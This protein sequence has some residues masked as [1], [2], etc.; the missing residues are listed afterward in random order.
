MA[1]AAKEAV[2]QR[3]KTPFDINMRIIVC[4]FGFHKEQLADLT[5]LDQGLCRDKAGRI[6]ADLPNHHLGFC[7]CRCVNHCLAIVERQRHR[8][9]AQDVLASLQCCNRDLTV[10]L[11]GR[12]DNDRIDRRVCKHLTVICRFAADVILRSCFIQQCFIDI[13][14]H[15]K[16]CVGM[17]DDGLHVQLRHNTARDDADVQLLVHGISS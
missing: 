15:I 13:A 8:L 10:R 16:L 7:L 3:I 14:D 5:A 2:A 9:F 4:I 6:A 1:A 17:V 11:V 12:D